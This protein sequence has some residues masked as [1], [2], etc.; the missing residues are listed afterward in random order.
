MGE[1]GRRDRLDVRLTRETHLFRVRPGGAPGWILVC[2]AAFGC[3]DAPT[4][5]GPVVRDSAG[6]RIVEN[7]APAWGEGEGLRVAAEPTVVIGAVDGPAEQ[8]MN[9][10]RDATVLP[11][12]RIALLNSGAERWQIHGADGTH[13]RTMGTRGEGPG[14]FQMPEW[15]AVRGDTVLI[16]DGLQGGGRLTRYDLSGDLLGPERV[17]AEGLDYASPD[18]MLSDGRY[19]DELSEGS[20]GFTEVGYV[21]Y[22][23]H[24]VVIGNGGSTVDTIASAPGGER[25]R[26]ESDGFIQQLDVPFGRDSYTAVG[27]ERLFLGDGHGSFLP[28]YDFAGTHL[29]S[30]GL[31]GERQPLEEAERE[32]W[33]DARVSV[34]SYEGRP[35]AMR[36][37]RRLYAA[38]PLPDSTPA[39]AELEV[40]AVGRLWV[41]RYTPPWEEANDWWVFAS[42]GVWLGTVSLPAGLRVFEIGE[43]YVLGVTQDELDVEYGVKHG[44]EGGAT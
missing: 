22:T 31:P 7:R 21:V 9:R 42:D 28:G 15:I 26:E 19:L 27:R 30:I 5:D 3:Q 8:Q 36:T 16:F 43:D 13:L 11:D 38:S 14:E 6:V 29:L 20:V 2:L 37:A 35:E 44:L 33:I 34:P 1:M 25:F 12:G 24:V 18:A 39:H 32:R 41:Q 17:E 40:D 23:R 10:V 4:A